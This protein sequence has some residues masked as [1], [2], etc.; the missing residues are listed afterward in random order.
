[1]LSDYFRRLNGGSCGGKKIRNSYGAVLL[2]PRP[3]LYQSR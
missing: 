3:M 2:I 1:L